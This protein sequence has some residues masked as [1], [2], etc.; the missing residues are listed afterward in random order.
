MKPDRFLALDSWRGICACL[1]A[2]YHLNAVSHLA[3]FGLIRA[4]YLF[5]D[6]FFVLSGFVIAANYRDRLAEG[7]GVGR[8]MMLRFG[9]VYPLHFAMILPFIFIDAA[10]DG[11]GP[12]LWRAV[13]T[14]VLMIHGL[15]VNEALWLNFPSWSISTEFAAYVL[16]ALFVPYVGRALWPWIIAALAG[17]VILGVFSV[18]GMDSTYD[19]GFVRC[20]EGFALGVICFSLREDFDLMRKRFSPVLDSIIEL[21]LVLL[22]GAYITFFW[23]EQS[24]LLVMPFMFAVV[25][26]VFAR[27]A[28][29]ISRLLV[30]RPFLLLGTLSYSIYM[31][32][33][34]VRAVVRAAGMVLE[35]YSNLTVFKLFPSDTASDPI[36]VLS[37]GDNLW[38]GDLLQ[39]AMLSMTNVLAYFS[40]RFIEEPGRNWSRKLARKKDAVSSRA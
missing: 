32:H 17:P 1:V 6:F 21:G 4:S 38:L 31:V 40:Y 9:R 7:F 24:L 28:G 23:Q 5:V 16:F 29:L 8:F 14:N 26:L 36:R 15:G 10:K 19:Y 33:A 12:Q 25:V 2:L 30:T 34:L 39:L 22:V 27:E 20:L 13:G 37:V 18:H 35:H 11:I 3:S